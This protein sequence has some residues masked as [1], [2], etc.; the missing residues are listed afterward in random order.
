MIYYIWKLWN[1]YINGVFPKCRMV[2]NDEYDQELHIGMEMKKH[3]EQ[4]IEVQ[5]LYLTQVE[6]TI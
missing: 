6:D 2:N 3:M 1:V 5:D 4:L